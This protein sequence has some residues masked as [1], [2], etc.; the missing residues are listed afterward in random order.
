M[1]RLCFS[2]ARTM[3]LAYISHLD[4]MRLF[5]RALRRSNL[6]LAYSQ[7]YN[8][9]PRLTL[10]LPLPVGVTA[11]E[12]LGE[13]FFAEA[14]SPEDFI[15][16]LGSQLPASLELTGAGRLSPESTSLAARVCAALYRVFVSDEPDRGTQYLLLRGALDKL[17]S[18][19]EILM[20]RKSKKKKITFINVRPYILKAEIIYKEGRPL[21]L[22]LLLKAGSSGGVSPFFIIEQLK[23]EAGSGLMDASSWHVHREKLYT[24]QNGSLQPLPERM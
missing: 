10:A 9:H 7:G 22:S 24:G 23:M 12:E 14:V 13:I 4:M 20:E 6:P 5:L 1:E 11:S 2:F 21:E 19:E 8:P 16:I 18:R 17:M 3:P 15:S